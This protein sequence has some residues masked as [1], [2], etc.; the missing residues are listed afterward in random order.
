MASVTGVLAQMKKKGKANYQAIY[1]RHGIPKERSFG[2][3]TSELKKIQ[4]TIKGE[5]K[6]AMELYATGK[7]EAMYLAG[8]VADGAKMTTKELN[9]WAATSHGM[10]MI[11]ECTVPWVA[12][13]NEAARE[14]ALKWIDSKHESIAASG[15]FTYAGVV[16]TRPDNE[17][18]L[19]EIESL[20][21]RIVKE[22]SGAPN[23]VKHTMNGF[24][25]SVGGYV[26]PL[27][28]EAKAAAR[29]IG[30]VNVDVGETECKIPFALEYIAKMEEM[31]RI[32]KKRKTMKC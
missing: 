4:K 11:S 5:Q 1:E 15:W 21:Q 24:V 14:L 31:G 16:S 17:L 25:I 8:L 6:L 26:K 32:G 20:L 3:L 22:I 30:K 28:K 13:E 18:D 12:T 7:M 29:E 23:R 2:V 27:L 9:D 19:A 10:P